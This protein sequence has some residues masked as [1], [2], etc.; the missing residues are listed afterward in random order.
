M[1][2]QGQRLIALGVKLVDVRAAAAELAGSICFAFAELTGQQN[3]PR[4][5]T[6]NGLAQDL[7]YARGLNLSPLTNLAFDTEASPVEPGILLLY[8]RSAV[9]FANLT[10]LDHESKSIIH[11]LVGFKFAV[12]LRFNQNEIGAFLEALR[13]LPLDPI[14]K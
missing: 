6:E 9:R 4:H 5:Y 14:F 2:V 13:I 8:A 10:K 11:F 1:V 3:I 7:D 12:N